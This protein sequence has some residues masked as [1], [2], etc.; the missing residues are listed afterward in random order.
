ML[1]NVWHTTI[2]VPPLSNN[3]IDQQKIYA[4][5]TVCVLTDDSI[6]I[7]KIFGIR[8]EPNTQ[9]IH[10]V[11]F[12]MN[13]QKQKEKCFDANNNK[14]KV[15]HDVMCSHCFGKKASSLTLSKHIPRN[16]VNDQHQA[17]SESI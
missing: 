15:F 1:S 5:C 14:Q 13:Y 7:Y 10:C 2:P 6:D 4:M 12:A 3:E 9:K 17:E 11:F 16:R 8:F